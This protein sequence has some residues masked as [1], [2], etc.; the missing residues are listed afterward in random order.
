MTVLVIPSGQQT[1][2]AL[3]VISDFRFAFHPPACFN[4][5]EF[6]AQALS[7]AQLFKEE[8]WRY[9][10]FRMPV[11]LFSDPDEE[12]T[13]SQKKTSCNAFVCDCLYKCG[14]SADSTHSGP[15]P[16]VA[17]RNDGKTRFFGSMLLDTNLEEFLRNP[18]T[19]QTPNNDWAVV[20]TAGVSSRVLPPYA[21]TEITDRDAI[22]CGD[23]VATSYR[24]YGLN[25]PLPALQ[26]G[27]EPDWLLAGHGFIFTLKHG[28]K[29]KFDTG[30]EANIQQKPSRGEMPFYFDWSTNNTKLD[31][32]VITGLYSFQSGERVETVSD[33]VFHTGFVIRK[34]ATGARTGVRLVQVCAGGNY[35]LTRFSVNGGINWSE[36]S[37]SPF[38]MRPEDLP[39][40]LN[41]LNSYS[42]IGSHT[43]VGGQSYS[44]MP[45]GQS[46]GLLSVFSPGKGKLLLQNFTSS[47]V[48]AER[49]YYPSDSEQEIWTSWKY[50]YRAYQSV[51]QNEIYGLQVRIDRHGSRTQVSINGT[52]NQSLNTSGGYVTL[53]NSIPE[54]LLPFRDSNGVHQTVAVCKWLS[55]S[56]VGEVQVNGSG[57]LKIGMTY[58]VTDNVSANLS[59]GD[60]IYMVL[61]YGCDM[62]S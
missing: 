25:E 57:E 4:T 19:A 16:T 34:E 3:G 39:D 24:T 46:G 61:V 62:D 6:L 30:S 26:Q 32:Q 49:I 54:V 59:L 33:A 29:A 23:I 56:V 28:R 55:S 12:R 47:T 13:E 35:F 11:P 41:D 10:S 15:F 43:Y 1:I 51:V 14:Y 20:R 2:E 7:D 50:L 38:T 27:Q 60:N 37:Y 8:K 36:W 21:W 22:S 44:N 58:R 18:D 5:A 48:E 9:T 45:A 40:D 53:V 31:R 52:L 42:Y 17:N